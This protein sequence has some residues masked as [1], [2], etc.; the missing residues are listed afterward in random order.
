M[1]MNKTDLVTVCV[2]CLLFV[3]GSCDEFWECPTIS[4]GY[5]PNCVCR[6]GS[7]Y[8]NMTNT[9]PNPNCPTASTAESSYPNCIC[10]QP[11]FAYS[12]YINDCFRVCPEHSTGHWP[13]CKCDEKFA[14][15]DK[16]T[17]KCLTCPADSEKGQLYP[18]CDCGKTG[19]Y[20]SYRNECMKCPIEDSIGIYPNCSCIHK[21]ATFN[22]LRNICEFCV[23]GSSGKIPKCVC[24]NGAEYN[25]YAN[26]CE[27]CPYGSEG[28]FPNCQ[29]SNG[30]LFNGYYCE[31]CPWGAMGQ[32]GNCSCGGTQTYDK[33]NNT[34]NECPS[35]S[36]GT[37][38]SCMCN[39]PNQYDKEANECLQCPVNS[40][41]TYPNCE[42]NNGLFAKSYRKCI[43]CPIN[44]T[45]IYPECE[46]ELENH[47]FS[48]YINECYVECG[49]ES[50]GLH[51]RC[52]CEKP[53]FY[54][55][56]EE[57]TCK[58][59]V[60]RECPIAS[61]GL[62]PDCLCVQQ[63]FAFNI[64]SWR[65]EIEDVHFAHYPSQFCPSGDYRWPQCPVT[66]DRN[67]LLSLVG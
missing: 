47:V 63:K 46:C 65:C 43:E 30:G 55:V 49:S 52:R 26:F 58:S 23:D 66:I 59:I 36:T 14:I 32:Y 24:N 50:I 37:H 10:T 11:N 44:S 7:N 5:P 13:T 15:F 3:V 41:G 22:E 42:C 67:A 60:G 9:C 51:P 28:I 53:G 39:E 18:D 1:E 20:D 8:D 33:E 27:Q 31:N 40:N 45:G 25:M 56:P 62:G 19:T 2:L 38:P 48:A 34:C 61:I 16:S 21:N 29:C 35:N 4:E 54:Y 6:Y 57:F 17:F 12:A 64:V